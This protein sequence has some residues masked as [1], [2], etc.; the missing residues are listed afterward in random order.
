MVHR[1]GVRETVRL[2]PLRLVDQEGSPREK[3]DLRVRE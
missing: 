2:A 1:D 3:Q